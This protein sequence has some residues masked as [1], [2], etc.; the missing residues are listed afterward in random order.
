MAIRSRKLK[1]GKTAYD[2][3]V[4]HD[5]KRDYVT[6]YSLA[7]ARAVE[8]E[9]KARYGQSNARRSPIT[10]QEYI[11]SV[12]W[13]IASQRLSATSKDTYEKEIRLRI[14]PAL[15]KMR[16]R[17]IDRLAIQSQML[18]GCATA[19]VAKKA[20]GVL[21]TILNEAVH[22][23]YISTN[24]ASGKFAMPSEG[25]RRDN[26]LV[27]QT[28]EEI[29]ALLDCVDSGGSECVRRIAYTGLLQ[30]LRPEERYA[31]DWDCFDLEAGSLTVKAARVAA[32]PQHGGVQDKAPKTARGAR[33]IPLH[34]RLRALVES[35][36]GEG[37]FIT[38]KDGGKISPSTAQKRWRAFLRDNPDCAPV[39][40]ENMRHSFATAYLAA[41][42]RIEVLSRM[43][44]HATISTTISR[45]YRPDLGVLS[46]DARGVWT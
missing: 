17:E 33:T 2:V 43:L 32:T 38:G 30:G 14:L 34:P 12:Y 6:M 15:G 1:G 18:D 45:Y 29:H 24:Y 21:K 23:G 4:K 11:Y 46:D 35:A 5:G 22:D 19:T 13:P 39:T 16:L 31:L 37:A 41:G 20:L 3:T 36:K 27:L 9:L 26:G 10:L 7:E 28:F 44:G 25:T 40:I 8:I 42:G